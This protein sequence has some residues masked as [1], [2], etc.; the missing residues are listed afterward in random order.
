M[1]H[2]TSP[3]LR[4]IAGAALVPLVLVAAGSGSRASGVRS[5][6]VSRA[7]AESPPGVLAYII[8]QQ[9]PDQ[10]SLLTLLRILADRGVEIRRALAPFASGRVRYSAGAYIVLGSQANASAAA[11]VLGPPGAGGHGVPNASSPATDSVAPGLPAL[12]GVGVATVRDS[13][14]IPVTPPVTVRPA[15]YVTPAG[16]GDSARRVVGVYVPAVAG[17]PVA[18]TRATMERFG[19]RYAPVAAS[20]LAAGDVLRERYDAMLLPDGGATAFASLDGSGLR[21]FIA[22][23]GTIVA[24]GSGAKWAIR[25]FRLPGRFDD[26]AAGGTGT[27]TGTG[28]S[29]GAGDDSALVRVAIDRGSPVAADMVAHALGWVAGGPATVFTPDTAHARVV[30]RYDA[31]EVAAGPADVARSYDGA[32]AIVDVPQ[33]H[34]RVVL[35]GFDPAYRGV[36]LA[37]LPLLWGALRLRGP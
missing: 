2:V 36:S 13:F 24:V 18:W 20:A 27:G 15:Q 5:G 6:Q 14:P 34:G 17:R 29:D 33:G 9:Q 25:A 35:F 10:S 28:T 7:A 31:S 30:A 19:V 3:A 26:I 16:F 21:A 22:A 1:L 8:P 37:T 32:A 11:T 23:G 4:G 12:L